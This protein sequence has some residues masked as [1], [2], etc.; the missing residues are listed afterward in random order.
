MPV[1]RRP[2]GDGEVEIEVDAAGQGQGVAQVEA[3]SLEP[4][5]GWTPAE[6]LHYP[7]DGQLHPVKLGV[8]LVAHLKTKDVRFC[9]Q[10]PVEGLGRTVKTAAGP[11]EASTTVIA[12]DVHNRIAI[13]SM[14]R[15]ARTGRP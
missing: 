4:G 10:T 6:A 13:P 5:L 1:K 8:A 11:I 12:K 7:E 2:P 3:L 15:I 9:L 14:G